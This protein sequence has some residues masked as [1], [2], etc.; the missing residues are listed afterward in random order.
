[1]GIATATPLR[2]IL[3]FLQA[4]KGENVTLAEVKIGAMLKEIPKA[5]GGDHGNQHTGGK[6]VI[7]DKNAKTKA[8]VAAENNITPKQ[9]AQFQQMAEHEDVVMEAIAEAR[10]KPKMSY[11]TIWALTNIVTASKNYA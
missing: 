8:E 2:N 7:Q 11:R 4:L 5:S 1:M 10:K 3:Q 9:V 6:I